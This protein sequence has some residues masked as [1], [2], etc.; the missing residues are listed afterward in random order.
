MRLFLLIL[1]LLPFW[2]QAQAYRQLS[3]T[4][5]IEGSGDDLAIH[6]G[7]LYV[8]ERHPRTEAF[9]LR[10]YDLES[11]DLLETYRPPKNLATAPGFI[12][13]G[14]YLYL[15]QSDLLTKLH[16]PS[17]EVLWECPFESGWAAQI[18]PEVFDK[19]IGISLDDLILIVDKETGQPFVELEGEE[20]DQSISL[21]ENFLIYA[22]YDG[23]IH[24][25][26]VQA[27]RDKF[28][29]D[30]DADMGYGFLQKGHRLIL[31]SG[32]VALYCM[33]ARDGSLIW[34]YENPALNY[35]CG[36]GLYEVP[37]SHKGKLYSCQRSNGLFVFEEATGK[38]L[39][40]VDVGELLCP[41]RFLYR[42]QILLIGEEHLFAYHPDT[43]E[44]RTLASF[45]NDPEALPSTYLKGD[46]L[47]LD[48]IGDYT[49]PQVLIFSLDA[50]IE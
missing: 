3:V 23:P 34:K 18:A 49:E 30:F 10:V 6:D 22:D 33:D 41:E 15:H 50:L 24:C 36:S 4:H 11:L 44:L 29:W 35:S 25:Y 43:E 12:L 46:Y 19:H 45:P 37:L 27:K 5:H 32:N 2:T 38:L 8:P 39:R 26:D 14:E 7:K 16:Y 1:L 17:Q 47:C 40:T 13:E 20:W 28:Q 9:S 21:N 42:G 48:Y 31:P